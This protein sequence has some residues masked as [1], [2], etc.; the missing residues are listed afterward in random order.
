MAF[1]DPLFTERET[2]PAILVRYSQD[3]QLKDKLT[4]LNQGEHRTRVFKKNNNDIIFLID[5]TDSI[6]ELHVSSVINQYCFQITECAKK[7]SPSI[8]MECVQQYGIL[9]IDKMLQYAFKQE[10]KAY[11][12]ALS[13]VPFDELYEGIQGLDNYD[14]KIVEIKR[15][16]E[17]RARQKEEEENAK[18]QFDV[19]N[20]YIG[21]ELKL[22]N[23]ANEP[24][25]LTADPP[26]FRVNNVYVITETL[27][28]R[29]A[30]DEELQEIC[31]RYE[32]RAKNG[33]IHMSLKQFKNFSLDQGYSFNG[34]ITLLMTAK[35]EG[36][37]CAREFGRE[38][39][40]QIGRGR[41]YEYGEYDYF[42]EKIQLTYRTDSPEMI[43]DFY[44]KAKFSLRFESVD[45]T[46]EAMVEFSLQRKCEERVEK[47]R[48]KIEILDQKGF[49][50]KPNMEGVYLGTL[51]K[52]GSDRRRLRLKL[53]SDKDEKIAAQEF[54]Y[55]QRNE[56]KKIY[57]G[58]IP[59]ITLLKRQNDVLRR[60]IGKNNGPNPR[61]EKFIFNSSQA[62]STECF[63]GLNSAEI[64]ST[65]EYKDCES[66]TLLALN[67]S[68]LEAVAKGLYAKDLC[69]LQGPPGTGK[70][71]VISELIWQH[72]RKNQKVRIMLTSQTNLAIDNALNRLFANPAI[73][74]GSSAW[75]KI[76]LIK[77]IRC[78]D[79]D[80]IEEEGMPFSNDRLEKWV[81]GE[82]EEESSNNI[83]A[84]WMSHISERVQNDERFAD[85]LDEWKQVLKSPDK[86][87]RRIF[88]KRYLESSN[89]FCVTCGK[90]DS[91][92]FR[93]YEAWK[94][95][96]V[97]IVDEASKATPP[98][99]LMP[100]WYAKKSIVIGDHRQ[101]PPVIFE[102]DFFNKVGKDAPELAETL[103]PEIKKEIVEESLFK[104]L[105]THPYLSSSIKATFNIQYRMHPDING[106]VSQFY[107]EDADGLICGLDNTKVNS[108]NITERESRWHGLSLDKF[109]NP[110]TH[111]IWVD[112]PDGV[113][114]GGD[115]SSTYNEKEVEAVKLVVEA[116]SKAEGF[117]RYMNAWKDHPSLETRITEGKIGIIS[118]YAA[119]CNK[120]YKSIQ[121][122]CDR[123]GI[124][125]SV[126]SVDKFQG[127][128]RG[129]VVVSTVRTKRLGF[130]KTP[131]R[132]NVALSR[133]RRLLIIVGN[134]KFYSS[135]SAKV[136][137]KHIYKNVID[138]IKENGVFINYNDLKTILDKQNNL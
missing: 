107:N 81:N 6:L 43:E 75:E 53:P 113:E 46:Q 73:K 18:K 10:G 60:I 63:V 116:L 95:F 86:E 30:V 26:D 125:R 12:N 24:F 2:R 80:K 123:N 82:C 47:R 96:D 29:D 39:N 35:C 13:A 65:D 136:G 115:G 22:L 119:Q 138:Y 58:L 98:E 27:V 31:E 110:S 88:K 137:D 44:N 19:W 77:P 14:A 64:A 59:D 33:K 91:Q 5:I 89:V 62:S 45:S 133:A 41:E 56:V 3:E 57:P 42:E 28:I 40:Y 4:S 118:F 99:L 85:L 37:H 120:I 135:D 51:C 25:T 21:T 105:I 68:Q 11:R 97:V 104:R 78:A 1:F 106:V 128:E 124:K 101:L 126:N 102:E 129:I 93:E 7:A 71:T 103:N 79:T 69:L 122:Y 15:Q 67:P 55:S 23:D 83:V 90:V 114:A 20:T 52:D 36:H 87:M 17:I 121:S 134:S 84:K 72:I 38:H 50:S 16:Q 117:D 76:M 61:L 48:N 127:Q 9:H 130:T 70:T 131:E 111:V 92:D 8:D 49:Y 100:L 94:G 32:Y 66:N 34:D 54:F 74:V 108:P 132:L 112:V 109:T